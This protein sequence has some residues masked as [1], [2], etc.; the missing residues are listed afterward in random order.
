MAFAFRP[1]IIVDLGDEP[2]KDYGS[3]NSAF[4]VDDRQKYKH[5]IDLDMLSNCRV[6]TM[7]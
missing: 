3:I 5:K 7:I 1:R 4:S 2:L 6:S